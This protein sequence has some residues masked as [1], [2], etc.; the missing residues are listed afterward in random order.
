MS[1]ARGGLMA[2][3]ASSIRLLATQIASADKIQKKKAAE[4]ASAIVAIE[5]GIPPDLSGKIE[6][7]ELRIAALEAIP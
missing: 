3:T 6:D 5:S 1:C 2:R 7:Y 4:A